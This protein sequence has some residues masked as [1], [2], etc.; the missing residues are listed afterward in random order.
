MRLGTYIR[1][2]DATPITLDLSPTHDTNFLLAILAALLYLR[3]I[4]VY[5]HISSRGYV[6]PGEV[7]GL[8]SAHN[9]GKYLQTAIVTVL[10]YDASK[11]LLYANALTGAEF[12]SSRNYG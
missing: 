10:V 11:E 3:N 8:V 2:L 9:S 6:D 4:S 7:A 5:M 1:A 12:Y